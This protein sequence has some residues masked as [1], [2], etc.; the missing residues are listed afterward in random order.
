MSA[1]PDWPASIWF[2]GCG[3]MAGAM[4]SRWLMCGLDATRVTVIDPAQRRS[5][6][7]TLDSLPDEP[8]PDLL[9]LGV[10]PQMLDA[11]G[12]AVAAAVGSATTLVSILAGV[13]HATLAGHFASAG[14]VVRVMPNMPVAIG[15]GAVVLYAPGVDRGP[16]DALMQPLGL[17][18]WLDDE[19]LFDA[20]TALSGS[21]PAFTYR[22]AEALA[23]GG[24]EL[25]LDDL[26]ADR[27]ARA[28]VA[29]AAALARASSEPLAA[30]AD[31]VASNGGSTRVGLD[32][33]ERRLD[34]L[35]TETLRATEARNRELGQG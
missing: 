11:V 24:T 17:V 3:A 2:M 18:E 8:A 31:R 15:E 23:K 29:G 30:L 32:V 1:S 16:L 34:A 14:K 21:G 20:V 26:L 19:A 10:K 33:L 13:R 25:G 9:L 6:V 22:F 7:R 5:D 27:L 28:T 4:L 12:E 35:L